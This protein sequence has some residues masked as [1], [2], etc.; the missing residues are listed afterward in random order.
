MR[1]LNLKSTLFTALI[2]LGLAVPTFAQTTDAKTLVSQ[3]TELHDQGKYEEAL[4]KYTAAMKA[5]PKYATAYYEYAY[6]LFTTGKGKEALDYLEKL[7]K[8][9]PKSAGG[10]DMLGS[11]YDDM[12]DQDKAITYYQKGVEADPN[13]QRLHFNLSITYYRKKLYAES[14]QEAL[15][16]I[17]LDPKHAS[18]HRMYG[19]AAY[20]LNKRGPAL[21]AFCNFL[22]LEPQTKRSPEIFNNVKKIVNYGVKRTDAKS[23]TLSVSPD[24]IG[25]M[26]MPMSVVTA[27]DKK[28]PLSGVDSLQYQLTSLFKIASTI[29]GGD[30]ADPFVAKYYA[31]YFKALA[32]T[33]NMPAFTRFI[34]VSAYPTENLQWFKEHDKELTAFDVWTRSTEHKF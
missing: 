9:D 3:G 18:S 16:A 13:Y 34:S 15:T 5:D 12:G 1:N 23:I 28:G 22:L 8:L 27:T 25:N 7:I 33:E 21:L 11:I 4:A 2:C 31:D 30:K 14:A 26:M 19:M 20:A 24:D 17:K 10:Y 6:T 32:E 29:A